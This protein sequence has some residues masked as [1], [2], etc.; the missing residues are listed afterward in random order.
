MSMPSQ[1]RDPQP[2]TTGG[3]EIAVVVLAALALGIVGAA[4]AGLGLAS[5]LF[6][7]GWVWPHGRPII[8]QTLRGLASGHPGVGLPPAL[9]AR[10]AARGAVYATIAVCELA[11]IA[12]A[13]TAG[14]LVARYRRPG[15]P[16][17]GMATRSEAAQVL[18]VGVLR[19]GRPI[20]RPDLTGRHAQ[21]GP[22]GLGE[23]AAEVAR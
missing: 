13:T 14:V 12:A 10:V 3:W 6:G 5:A 23:R 16:G 15:G 8:G 9:A 17:G 4:F 2:M 11:A 20:I 19:E 7:R 1:R 18:G 21:P 22:G